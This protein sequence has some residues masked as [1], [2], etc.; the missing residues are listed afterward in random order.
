M[1]RLISNLLFSSIVIMSAMP[2]AA[3][4]TDSMGYGGWNNPMS[5][6][7]STMLWSRLIYRTPQDYKNGTMSSPGTASTSGK[8][9][10]SARSQAQSQSAKP[11]DDRSVKFRSTG[12]YL[13][14]GDLANSLGN[15]PAEREQYLKLMNAVLDAFN[16]RA[17]Q[18]GLQNDLALALSY[19]L[20]E[21]VRIYR[22]L[23]DLSDQQFV[24]LR[25]TIAEVLA[26][27]GA[28]NNATDRQKQEFY[29][30]LVAYTG[31]TQYGYEQ[32]LKAQSDA[33]IKGYQKIAGQNLQTVTKTAPGDINFGASGVSSGETAMPTTSS[34]AVSVGT[35][36]IY[37]LRSDYY[38]NELRADQVYKGKRFVFTGLASEISKV[39]F[40][41]AGQ[42]QSGRPIYKDLGANLKVGNNGG[43]IIGWQVFCFFRDNNQLA[44]LQIRQR[45]NF[46]ATVEGR[47]DDSTNLYLSDAILR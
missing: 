29:E 34:P 20:G 46:E 36:D 24:D 35:V 14:T 5:S 28:L 10:Q 23:P 13:R 31:I 32:G 33:I 18:A 21:N 2:V 6:M 42:D 12:T 45:I 3:Q 1:K 38:A 17:K 22:G 16:Q 43:S 30:A 25:N 19:F 40:I 27:T 15:T 7:M 4:Y 11:L 44:Q 26:S 39:H 37:Q 47:R 8:P 41:T 9:S